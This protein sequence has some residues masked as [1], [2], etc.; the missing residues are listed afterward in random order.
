[1]ILADFLKEGVERNNVIYMDSMPGIG[2]TKRGYE[3]DI[4]GVAGFVDFGIV[5]GGYLSR[6]LFWCNRFQA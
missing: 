3:S 2:Y 1:M 4:N 5:Q 6:N